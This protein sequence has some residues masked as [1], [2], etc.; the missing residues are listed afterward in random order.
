[1]HV[2]QL[3]TF[4]FQ[5]TATT[6]ELCV[7]VGVC[8]AASEY[9]YSSYLFSEHHTQPEKLLTHACSWP[10]LMYLHISNIL[11]LSLYSLLQ[12]EFQ[13]YYIYLVTRSGFIYLLSLSPPSLPTSQCLPCYPN[14]SSPQG[15]RSPPGVLWLCLLLALPLPC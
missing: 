6:K 7:V 3:S 2:F 1:M 5:H 14:S 15:A 9:V 12:Q 8:A 11:S 10:K 13:I 4:N